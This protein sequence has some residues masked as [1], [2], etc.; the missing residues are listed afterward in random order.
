MPHSIVGNQ[1]TLRPVLADSKNAVGLAK[2]NSAAACSGFATPPVA[3]RRKLE[4]VGSSY[5]LI[6]EDVRKKLAIRYLLDTL[7]TTEAIPINIAT[8]LQPIPVTHSSAGPVRTRASDRK[9]A[10]STGPCR[11]RSPYPEHGSVP[12][13][14]P[15]QK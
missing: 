4:A 2:P 14:T 10:K 9:T 15:T 3:L 12:S 7:L 11:R 5:N 6:L 13:L 8:A 1:P